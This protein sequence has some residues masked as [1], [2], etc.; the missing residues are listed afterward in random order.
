MQVRSRLANIQLNFSKASKKEPKKDTLE[1][2]NKC[3]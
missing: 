2:K 1:V 3:S